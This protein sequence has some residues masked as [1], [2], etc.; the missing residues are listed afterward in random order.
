MTAIPEIIAAQL[1]IV[2]HYP[3]AV[4]ASASRNSPMDRSAATANARVRRNK[5]SAL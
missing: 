3:G 5:E 2:D 4:H 1:V